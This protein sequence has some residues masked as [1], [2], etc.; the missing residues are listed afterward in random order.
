MIKEI[1]FSLGI[2]PCIE[3]KLGISASQGQVSDIDGTASPKRKGDRAAVNG[4][5]IWPIRIKNQE[6]GLLSKVHFRILS[7]KASKVRSML[8]FW[9]RFVFSLP[10]PPPF[11]F[12]SLLLLILSYSKMYSLLTTKL[13]IFVG[14][15][16]SRISMYL[17][18]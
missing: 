2:R 8:V 13:F 3:E 11:F 6:C 12:A 15:F 14:S 7:W 18:S 5:E 4:R 1:S 16:P 17:S 9:F 10:L